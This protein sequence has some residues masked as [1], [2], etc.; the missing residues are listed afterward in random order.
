MSHNLGTEVSVTYEAAGYNYDTVVYQKEKPPL[1]SELNVSQELLSILRQRNTLNLPSGWLTKY[2]FYTSNTL[3]NSFYTQDPAQALPEYALV[4]G[5]VLHVTY[6]GTTNDNMNL[7]DLGDPPSSGSRVNGIFLEVW[8]A[9][10]DPDSDTN[11]PSVS[12]IIDPLN[13]IYMLTENVGWAVGGFGTI[14]K[15]ENGGLNWNAK[16]VDT[17]RD[18]NGVFFVNTH[19]GW[20][21]GT[22]GVIARSSSGGETWAVLPSGVELDLN[23]IYAVNQI[24]AWVAGDAGTILKT[25]NGINW[26]P[27]SSGVVKNLNKVFFLDVQVGWV[28]GDDGTILK[29]VD[30][31]TTWLAQN[32]GTTRNLNSIFFFNENLGFAVGDSGTI[33][34]SS[35]GGGT[36]INQSNNVY[37][38][39]FK[40]ITNQLKDVFVI[41]NLDTE[42]VD[43]EVSSQMG[44]TNKNFVTA[45][46][47]ITKG[48]G[49][50]VTSTNPNDVIVTVNGTPVVVSSLNGATGEVILEDIPLIS[51][52]VKVTYFYRSA[53]D[54][55]DRA[56]VVGSD[57]LVLRSE[58]IGAKWIEQN[59]QTV[60]DVNGIFFVNPNAGW[61]VA[62]SSII[63]NTE[64]GGVTWQ[65]QLSEVFSRLQQRVFFEGNTGGSVFLDDNS[66]HPDANVET[67]KR[68]QIQY[69]LRVVSGVDPS[70]YPDAGLGSPQVKAFGPNT[71]GNFQYENQGSVTGDYGLWKARC[72]NTVDEYCWAI[73]LAFVSR[74]NTV[75]YDAENNANG[76]TI[77]ASGFIRP[78]FLTAEWVTD[79]DILDVR[80]KVPAQSPEELLAVGFDTLSRN[81]LK[82]LMDLKALGGDQYGSELL[83]VDL[84][85]SGSGGEAIDADLATVA[86]GTI[87]SEVDADNTEVQTITATTSIPADVTMP[88]KANGVYH[89]NPAYY[90]AKYAGGVL[91]GV[92]VPG[93]FEGVGTASP[94][95]KFAS[96]VATK[97]TN[98]N[99]TEYE[100]TARYILRSPLGLNK[101]P[102]APHMVVNS[103]PSS[104]DIYYQGV[105][106]SD[107]SRV[108]ETWDSTNAIGFTNYVQA[109]AGVDDPNVIQRARASTVEMH[110]FV[111]VTSVT[112]PDIQTLIINRN[113]SPDGISDYVIYTVSEVI[114]KDAGF[115]LKIANTEISSSS[116]TI[117]TEPGFSFVEGTT[118]EVVAYVQAYVE[119]TT[120]DNTTPRNGASVNFISETRS[121]SPFYRSAVIEIDS[122]W[123]SPITSWD[124]ASTA[125]TIQ[126]I[127]SANT[128]DSTSQYVCWHDDAGTFTMIPLTSVTGFDTTQVSVE[129]AT[130]V[131]TGTLILQA[132]VKQDVLEHDNNATDSLLI[133]YDYVPSQISS[134][135]P[136]SLS[137]KMVTAPKTISI[138]NMGTGG[139]T[140]GVPYALPM[141]QIPVNDELILEDNNFY[142]IEALKFNNISV[143]TG[144]VEMPAYVPGSFGE[145]ITLSSPIKDAEDRWFY[146]ASSKEFSFETEGLTS[147][148]P[149]KIYISAI[150]EVSEDTSIFRKGELLMVVF[151]KNERLETANSVG[152]T[153]NS[154]SVAAVYRLPNNPM[155]RN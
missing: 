114:N 70:A 101:T 102:A 99:L 18:L 90:D 15:T 4:N 147:P 109:F 150:A 12:S 47:P 19:I 2:P 50:G 46:R 68:V 17:R 144:Y 59:S 95:F 92:P 25:T 141:D 21:V 85:G 138:S 58:D 83:Q 13:S 137:L 23:S 62:D 61:I 104:G 38:G 74:R 40:S 134:S 29:T 96:N 93:A 33:L 36:W 9:L 151:S 81:N 119:P 32:S 143:S 148:N 113:I 48:D 75:G 57:G 64:D 44:G 24:T 8:R 97:V 42:V 128:I 51:D 41:A 154:N 106:V 35:D 121:L 110:Y 146:S 11:K 126:G 67:T 60:E 88:S 34:R 66:I 63:R 28:V 140:A 3:T 145:V 43:E 39:S 107:S 37:D 131:N 26:S 133:G 1:D 84:V 20:T 112:S 65:E 53:C 135:L 52:T 16:L 69:R 55:P 120:D 139:G 22:H 14:I 98:P 6:T 103:N 108:T 118:I 54:L 124:F 73:P 152:F 136:T 129:L 31:G 130:G 91:D 10:L 79:K 155:V 132:T 100:I 27:L 71:S 78:D 123:P 89:P 111:E 87:T 5:W 56:W 49:T 72:L 45:N 153:N 77:A 30:G 7:I 149:R 76:T 115:S 94:V 116:I 82:T 86:G 80:R 122:V 125:G 127:S 117:T 105:L 142:N